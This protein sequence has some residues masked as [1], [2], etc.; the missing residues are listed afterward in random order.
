M[1]IHCVSDVSCS[2]TFLPADGVLIPKSRALYWFC[3]YI[4]PS[5]QHHKIAYLLYR[6]VSMYKRDSG[7]LKSRILRILKGLARHRKEVRN[8][9]LLMLSKNRNLTLYFPD[10]RRLEVCGHGGRSLATLRVLHRD[11]RG[12]H[13][14]PDGRPPHLRVRRPRQNHRH[15]P[16]QIVIRQYRHFIITEKIRKSESKL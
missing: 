10:T 11:N 14:D 3:W 1:C 7:P 6:S 16:R 15:L 12:H 5:F 8:L 4:F 2:Q 9:T 13:W